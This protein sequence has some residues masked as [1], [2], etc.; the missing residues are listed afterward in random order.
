MLNNG[1]T[2]I[3]SRDEFCVA[4]R[5]ARERS[6]ITLADIANATKI[7]ASLFAALERNDLRRWPHGLFRRSFFRD[8]VQMIDLPVSEAVA[9]F[10]RLFPDDAAAEVN[11]VAETSARVELGTRSLGSRLSALI[12][13]IPTVVGSVTGFRLRIRV[14]KRG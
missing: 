7:P 12:A 5:T 8:Y 2:S 14:P 11:Q 9:A 10:V 6:G 3:D 13:A 4:L 1:I